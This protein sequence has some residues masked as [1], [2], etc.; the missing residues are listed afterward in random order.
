MRI[1]SGNRE[2]G[3]KN[4]NGVSIIHKADK[5]SI[6]SKFILSLK[7]KSFLQK[8]KYNTYFKKYV[9]KV[10]YFILF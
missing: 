9:K 7:L 10:N 8:L 5:S 6:G 1:Q 2:R 4:Q 3:A